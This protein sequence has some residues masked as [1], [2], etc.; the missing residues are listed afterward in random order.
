[1]TDAPERIWMDWPGV[2]RGE[3]I[4]D[5]PPK[6]GDQPGQTEYIRADLVPAMA[7]RIEALEAALRFGVALIEGD[8]FGHEWKKGQADFRRMAR[9]ALEGK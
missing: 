7:D 4:Y 1:M 2:D 8:S 6:R 9:A 5:T 3:P